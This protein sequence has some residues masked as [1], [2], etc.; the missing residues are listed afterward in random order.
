MRNLH[1]EFSTFFCLGLHCI[2]KHGKSG[3]TR[4]QREIKAVK[5]IAKGNFSAAAAALCSMESMKSHIF[6]ENTKL[7][8]LEVV[9]YSK[10]SDNMLRVSSPN[11]VSTFSNSQYYQQLCRM[12]PR[13]VC[14][15]AAI[16]KSGK[17][18][19]LKNVECEGNPSV[20]HSTLFRTPH[21]SI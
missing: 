19:T 21:R 18:A 11:S 12:C 3:R 9:N 17:P 6:V 1:L 13:L 7:T 10:Q 8:M 16:C 15:L 20:N 2:P 4:V 14:L 5:N